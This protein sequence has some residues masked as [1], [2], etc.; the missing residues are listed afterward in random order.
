[1]KYI[2]TTLIILPS[3]LVATPPLFF[4]KPTQHD[5]FGDGLSLVIV[6]KM[7]KQKMPH[8]NHPN[9]NR[10][11][12]LGL[13]SILHFANTG[14]VIWGSG[15]NGKIPTSRCQFHHLDVRAVRGPKTRNFLLSRNID[16]PEVYGDP[17]ILLPKLFPMLKPTPK[18]EYI[19]IP[20]YNDL[21]KY[22]TCKNLVLP[23]AKNPMDV[24]HEILQAKLVISSS[25]HGIV[26][27]EAFG[28]PAKWLQS[29]QEAPF[30]YEDYYLGTHREIFRPAK[31]IE[32]ALQS[33]GEPLP[34]FDA[35]ALYLSF[36]WDLI[37]SYIPFVIQKSVMARP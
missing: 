3:L 24:V 15:L 4:Y 7:L 33:G 34:E 30:K 26:V 2:L 5:N 18:R 29:T 20:N 28:I 12:L 25:L 8:T 37:D 27:A 10:K 21:E 13:G 19:V 6:E 36:P 23:T 22:K 32:D 1:M 9:T 16:C 14:D 35:D 17:A 11:K 31:S